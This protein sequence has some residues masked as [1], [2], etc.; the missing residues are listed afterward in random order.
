MA[1]AYSSRFESAPKTL[2]QAGVLSGRNGR[3][4]KSEGINESAPLVVLGG[5]SLSGVMGHPLYGRRW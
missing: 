5:A 3:V 2:N 4:N 1:E